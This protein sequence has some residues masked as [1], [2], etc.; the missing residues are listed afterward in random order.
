MLA[1]AVI[2]RDEL[3]IRW[4]RNSVATGN[5]HRTLEICFKVLTL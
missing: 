5:F 4:N 3:Y 1:V 2:L